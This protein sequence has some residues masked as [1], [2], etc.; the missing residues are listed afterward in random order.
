M[1]VASR[2]LSVRLALPP[3]VLL[4]PPSP[5]LFLHTK[6]PLPAQLPWSALCE[7]LKQVHHSRSYLECGAGPV[8]H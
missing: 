3:Q 4:G 7:C 6:A 5:A 8:G 2:S 1:A